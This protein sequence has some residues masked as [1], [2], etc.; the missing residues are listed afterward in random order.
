MKL[1][2]VCTDGAPVMLDVRSGIQTLMK[3]VAQFA[4][5]SQCLIHRYALA[6]KTLSPDL[7]DT[8]TQVVKIV[9]YI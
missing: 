9:S 1:I 4:L 5:F 6:V 7:L 3:E 8:F 2:G